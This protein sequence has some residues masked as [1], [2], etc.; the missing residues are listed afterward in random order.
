MLEIVLDPKQTCLE[1]IGA[2]K[3]LF[4][5][6]VAY[7]W[8]TNE[9]LNSKKIVMGDVYVCD[10]Y[11]MN[12]FHHACT[13]GDRR[14]LQCIV[15]SIGLRSEMMEKEERDGRGEG[16]RGGGGR[17]GES[18]GDGKGEKEREKRDG[19]GEPPKNEGEFLQWLDSNDEKIIRLKSKLENSKGRQKNKIMDLITE[20]QKL[21]KEERD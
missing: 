17:K 11:G 12:I 9:M 18:K 14:V 8:R 13:Q 3:E 7:G 21:K 19:K 15:S 4:D 20:I 2:E 10:R 5:D 6:D 16:E 1:K